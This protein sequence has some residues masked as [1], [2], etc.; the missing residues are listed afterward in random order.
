MKTIFR[1]RNVIERKKTTLA[2]YSVNADENKIFALLNDK[3]CGDEQHPR[4][5]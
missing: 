5:I 3:R 1:H 4:E 2:E